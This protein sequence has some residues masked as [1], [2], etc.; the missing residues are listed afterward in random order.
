MATRNDVT[1][2]LIIS[3]YPSKAFMDNFDRIFRLPKKEEKGAEVGQDNP[4]PSEVETDQ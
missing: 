4:V 3:K 1:G 2:D